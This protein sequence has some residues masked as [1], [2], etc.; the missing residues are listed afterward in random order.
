MIRHSKY[1]LPGKNCWSGE[2]PH[3]IIR[4]ESS[5][6]SMKRIEDYTV[7]DLEMTGLA[8]KLDKIIEIGAVRV[9][10]CAVADTYA[11]L[12]DPKIPIP[13]RVTELTGITDEM[14]ASGEEM[15]QAVQGLIDFIGDDVLVGQ[16]I[17]FDYSFIKQWAVNHKQ[18]LSMCAYDTLKLARRYLPADMSKK[19]ES[20]CQYFGIKRDNA[21][22]ALD[23]AV[24]TMQVFEKLQDIAIEKNDMDFKPQE[25]VYKAKKQSPATAHQI[26]RLREFRESFGITEPISWDTLTRSQASRIQ[27][28]YISRYGRL[29]H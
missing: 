16:N 15:D 4:L 5:M 29:K 23:D 26:E 7:V 9:R 25:L 28:E 21:H 1:G 6:Q 8:A 19:L 11:M 20:L 22:R 14:A 2:E 3:W 13:Q 18:S 12:V 27:D 10:G 17:N 24:E